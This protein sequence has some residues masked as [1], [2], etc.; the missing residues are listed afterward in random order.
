LTEQGFDISVQT[1]KKEC[2]PVALMKLP[3]I[4]G[5]KAV[6]FVLR[7]MEEAISSI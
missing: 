6:D 2:P 7:R 3:I 5:R 4:M 1:Y